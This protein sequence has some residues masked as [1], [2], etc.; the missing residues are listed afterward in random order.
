MGDIWVNF[1]I[2]IDNNE[3]LAAVDALECADSTNSWEKWNDSRKFWWRSLAHAPESL[4]GRFIISFLSI[5]L[6]FNT[7]MLHKIFICCMFMLKYTVYKCYVA[8]EDR[9]GE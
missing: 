4:S 6:N 3:N 2:A 5:F 8:G 1:V 7:G 9:D